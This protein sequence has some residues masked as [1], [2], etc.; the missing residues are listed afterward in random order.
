MKQLANEGD[1]HAQRM[2]QNQTEGHDFAERATGVT[3]Q[4]PQQPP[5][6]A[7]TVGA[8]VCLTLMVRMGK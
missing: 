3:R 1:S 5:T 4:Q 2:S 8:R 6:A 7:A